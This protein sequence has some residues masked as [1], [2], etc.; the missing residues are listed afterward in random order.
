MFSGRP[1]SLHEARLP[2]CSREMFHNHDWLIPRSGGRPWL[3]R[4]PLPHWITVATTA[5]LGQGCDSVWVVRLPAAMMGCITVLLTAWIASMWFG[6]HVALCAGLILATSYEFYTYACLAE[7]DIYLA[8]LVV[9]A[10]ALFVRA[11]F[12][13]PNQPVQ[14]R[15]GFFTAR[16]WPVVAFFVVLGLSNLVKGPLVG[17]M[18]VIATIGP[19]LLATRDPSS[20]RRFIWLWGWLIFL[21]LTAAWPWVVYHRYPEVMENWRF[22]YAGGTHQ[23]DQPFWYYPVQ[24]LGELAPWTPLAFVGLIA[25]ARKAPVATSPARFLW[26]WAII[27]ILFLSLPHRKHHHYLVPHLAPWAI[28]GS[29][30]LMEFAK[31]I[32]RPRPAP[33]RPTAFAVVAIIGAAA[34][35]VLHQYIPGALK[36]TILLAIGWIVCVALFFHGIRHKRPALLMATFVCGLAVTASWAQTFLPDQVTQDT[37]FLKQIPAANSDHLPLYINS[38]LHGELD[39]FRIGFYLPTD[40]KLLHNLSFLRDERIEATE[41][42]VIT[43]ARDRSKLETLGEVQELLQS[44][45][46]RGEVPPTPKKPTP[47]APEDRF[48]LFRLTFDP[49]LR[50]Y[51]A[52]TDIST[53]EA[54]G[55]K[56]GPWCG[57]PL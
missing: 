34:L 7:D 48:T 53:M 43:R 42:L 18:V 29:I 41:V 4:P 47:P 31:L 1:L 46:A 25:T 5:V 21:I 39:F 15:I 40:A 52:P 10:I 11:Q 54:M 16:S 32:L 57:P 55:R 44:A 23:Y 6:R 56:T 27:P 50:R 3:E 24:L 13:P 36:M 51:P 30:G 12:P 33:L 2:E 28:L 37:L 20:S 26:C 22:D 35:L 8:A 19:F 14:P 17:P 49:N 9:G 45:K 38:D